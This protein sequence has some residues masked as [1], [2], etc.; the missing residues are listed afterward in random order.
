MVCGTGY[1]REEEA[2]A[3][4]EEGVETRAAEAVAETGAEALTES[5]AE[6]LGARVSEA[7]AA[8]HLEALRR[9]SGIADSVIEARGYRTITKSSE[10]AEL[11]FSR[12]QC[13]AP[14]LLLPLHTTDGSAG[15]AVY[16]PDNARVYD[17]K[18]AGRLPDG[19]YRP[20]V[21]KYELPKDAGM[22][23]DCPPVCR[24]TLGDP[25]V[26]LW[27]TEGQKKA[28]A[29]ASRGLCA[30]ALLGVWNFKG[31]NGFGGT[32]LLADFDS[33]AWRGREVRIVFDS[34]AA[35]K[36]PV[37]QALE[38]LSEHLRRRGAS[39]AAA[40]LPA[41]ADGRKAGV[42]DWLA[43]GHTAE[44]LA[45]LAE[46]P[47]PAPKAPLPLVELLDQA[48]PRLD[49]P[50]K[51]IEQADTAAGEGEAPWARAYAATWLH[52]RVTRSVSTDRRGQL[53]RHDP[54]LITTEQQLFV[55]AG[56]GA[57]RDE[58]EGS[59]RSDVRLYGE[60]ADAPLSELG[61]EV[62]LPETPPTDVLWSAH[63]VKAYRHGYRP[64]PVDLF[65]RLVDIPD[66]FIDFNRSLADQRTM[67]E[68]VGCYVL[69]TWFL[70]AFT[71]IGFLWPNGD[72]GSGKTQ[73]ISVIA[74]LAY[75]GQVITAGGS[76][77]S[78]RDL[79]DY[80][81]TLAFDD[82][83][84]L[85][86]VRRTDPDKRTLLL[87]GNRRG[88][89]VPLKELGPDQKWRTRYVNTFCPRLFSA[90]HIP[91]PILASRTI[92]VPLVRTPDR[93]RA[94]VDPEDQ[95]AWPHPRR[96]LIDDC[97]ALAVTHLPELRA[98]EARVND[99]AGLAG[100]ALEPWRAL[101]AVALWLDDQDVEG[102]LRR[103]GEA[104]RTAENSA[105]RTQGRESRPKTQRETK[106]EIEG[107]FDWAGRNDGEDGENDG[108][109][110][111]N[112]GKDGGP[113]PDD[114]TPRPG[115]SP[116]C[117]SRNGV[118]VNEAGDGGDVD[119]P[120]MG[121]FERMEELSRVY[122]EERRELE[123]TDLM[124]LTI[125]A[126]CQCAERSERAINTGVTGVDT[127]FSAINAQNAGFM[128]TTSEVQQS[129]LQAGEEEIGSER[130]SV[131]KV[132]RILARMRLRQEPRPGGKGSRRW[133]VTYKDLERW[134]AAY[135]INARANE[136][137]GEYPP[138]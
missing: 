78:L 100:R 41:G 123:A 116:H 94:N 110:G 43:A 88:S 8:R 70:D 92:V 72:R 56:F 108:E 51:L 76:F 16:R 113:M 55:V 3:E 80:G 97:W 121:L 36:L 30:I 45:K 65:E 136:V 58:D 103:S 134:K 91:D 28:D 130:I 50:L 114:L 54:P 84:N 22:R 74:R 135:S 122:Q 68:M 77:P 31:R 32:T 67:A 81:A 69:A 6:T 83:E 86:D 85:S 38:R 10:L 112:D 87:A 93:Y 53:V 82:A 131:H 119:G 106:G 47:R 75:L 34:D 59:T 18:R 129:I 48:P 37:Q 42:D 39:V 96:A 124:S 2:M 79:A 15:P 26:T 40:Y 98:Y 25:A 118:E 104:G 57:R 17:D 29:L 99:R 125:R 126:L 46:S 132:G 23:V 12:G 95:A 21:I 35:S 138:S 71:V 60:G 137:E 52:V 9:E 64:D 5:P 4:G 27:V 73:L 102:R 66:R 109:D 89:S 117:G 49:R 44:E 111:E 61:C 7:L 14:G 127:L 33:I 115:G 19:T 90:T 24:A 107:D 1:L 20:R 11:G 13:R 105:Q 128:V 62:H 133:R 63:G 120:P 101:L